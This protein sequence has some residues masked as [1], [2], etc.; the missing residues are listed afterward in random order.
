MVVTRAQAQKKAT[1]AQKTETKMDKKKPM[2]AIPCSFAPVCRSDIMWN[3][4]VKYQEELSQLVTTGALV[5]RLVMEIL[6][7]K[8]NKLDF[9]DWTGFGSQS[10]FAKAIRASADVK[11]DVG[12]GTVLSQDVSNALAQA[13]EEYFDIPNRPVLYTYN[14][15]QGIAIQAK[16]MHTALRT[17][18]QENLIKQQR[19]ILRFQVEQIIQQRQYRLP[20]DIKYKDV[21][22]ILT[23]ELAAEIRQLPP[24]QF[25]QRRTDIQARPEVQVLRQQVTNLIQLHRDNMPHLPPQQ[26]LT[27]GYIKKNFDQFIYYFSHLNRICFDTHNQVNDGRSYLFKKK[28]KR[29]KVL[30]SFSVLP[31]FGLKAR[32]V[33]INL[34][35]MEEII[36][37]GRGPVVQDNLLSLGPRSRNYWRSRTDAQKRQYYLTRYDF[38]GPTI[39]NHLVIGP[40]S[41]SLAELKRSYSNLLPLIRAIPQYERHLLTS[42]FNVTQRTRKGTQPLPNLQNLGEGLRA[43]DMLNTLFHHNHDAKFLVT[44]DMH[45]CRFFYEYEGMYSE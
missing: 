24:P 31:D 40:N 1:K 32:F 21:L 20:A 15:A 10:F 22:W 39:L 13:R 3:G 37:M 25:Q 30:R 8:E 45:S 14:L 44:T 9:V 18:L 36:I 43:K 29:K 35:T 26:W 28:K 34:E 5:S 2:K 4:L 33:T 11:S 16:M 7:H 17:N 23:S 19:K 12:A 38:L 41:I 27:K 42:V 6:N